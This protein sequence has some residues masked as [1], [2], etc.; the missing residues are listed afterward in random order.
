MITD[1][2]IT[3]LLG[4][5]IKTPVLKDSFIEN[6]TVLELHKSPTRPKI[7]SLYKRK[8]RIFERKNKII[9]K[10]NFSECSIKSPCQGGFRGFNSKK[11]QEKPV[12]EI[13]REN[14]KIPKISQIPKISKIREIKI[15]HILESKSEIQKSQKW[16]G[17]FSAKN[18]ATNS[19]KANLENIKQTLDKTFKL[20]PRH[21]VA[22]LKDLEVRNNYQASRGLA[23]GNRMILNTGN[24]ESQKELKSVFVHEMGHVVDL[25]VLKGKNGRRTSFWDG[26]TPIYSDDPSLKF[27]RISWRSSEEKKSNAK[28]SDFVS[29]Y[30]KSSV[31]E[32]FAET[33]IFYR[34]HGEKFRVEMQYSK[35]LQEK[36][37]FMKN[38]VFDGKEFQ[39]EK[40]SDWQPKYIW[41][42][43]LVK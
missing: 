16:N 28:S 19:A 41:D 13:L 11:S 6:K 26:K 3:L 23:N 8:K 25:G 22:S 20:L 36:Y 1:F 7:F 14:Y 24:I 33:Y 4:T 31:F 35:K 39:L 42:A 12:F 34:L 21:H 32:D 18:Y 43:T 27:Y 10:Y 17:H 2:I 5:S 40:K 9:K 38:I 30:A 15:P 37:N 29:G